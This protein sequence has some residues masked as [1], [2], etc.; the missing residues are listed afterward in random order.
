MPTATL[1]MAEAKRLLADGPLPGLIDV[2]TPAEFAAC[3]AAGARSVPLDGL[4][5]D[6]VAAG[7]GAAGGPI[8]LICRSGAR[9][10]RAG[11]RLAA[12]GVGPAVVVEGGTVAWERAGLPVE[13]GPAGPIAMDRQVRIAAGSLVLLGLA[14]AWA[15]RPWFAGVSAAVAA[16]LVFSGVTDTC[17]MARALA[18]MPWN[19][20]GQPSR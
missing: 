12:A 1:S 3:H 13:R 2:R 10:A 11:E 19:R 17:G 8:Y 7:R 5:V 18:L 4:D 9:A 16:G 6:A 14:L 15:V 20:R